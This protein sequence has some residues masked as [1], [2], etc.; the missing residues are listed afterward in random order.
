MR[1]VNKARWGEAHLTSIDLAI[2]VEM[3]M[4]CLRNYSD[5]DGVDASV[6][7]AMSRPELQHLSA[8]E[9]LRVANVLMTLE[10]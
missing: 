9:R 10:G 2:L 3:D 8:A 1:D 4:F 5:G 7:A 6:M